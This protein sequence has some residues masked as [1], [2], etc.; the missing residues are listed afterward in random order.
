MIVLTRA[1]SCSLNWGVYTVI[2]RASSKSVKTAIIVW[3][4]WKKG[5]NL[6]DEINI[7]LYVSNEISLVQ[8][9][10][11]AVFIRCTWVPKRKTGTEYFRYEYV[12]HYIFPVYK[13]DSYY[14]VLKWCWGRKM[15]NTSMIMKMRKQWNVFLFL[16]HIIYCCL[17]DLNV[18]GFCYMGGVQTKKLENPWGRQ[19]EDINQSL[20]SLSV[21]LAFK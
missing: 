13:Q 10:N 3:I 5:H 14:D 16:R 1:T 8:W 19:T 12:Y 7:K 15:C 6:K 21:S 11:T 2:C 9:F 20:W 4:S 18:Y 17:W